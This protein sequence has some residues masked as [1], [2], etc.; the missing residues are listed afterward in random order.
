MTRYTLEQVGLSLSGQRILQPLDLVI[1][2][3]EALALL[4]PSGAGKTTLLRLLSLALSPTKGRLLLDGHN[5]AESTP[6]ALRALRCEMGMVHQDLALVPT[7]RVLD[8]VL[9]GGAGR[10][11]TLGALRRVAFPTQA[12][13]ESV[14]SLLTD[15]GLQDKLYQP[16]RSLSG[17]EAQRVALARA[18]HQQP[19]SLLADEPI[20][21]VDPSQGRALLELMLAQCAQRGITLVLSLHSPALAQAL[22]PRVIG[23]RA[24]RIVSDGTQVDADLY[25]GVGTR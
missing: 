18:L 2:E 14:H 5:V 23:L 20:S 11:S 8:N 4:G 19:R 17:G 25:A 1:Q 13:I 12:E 16:V 3:G 10:L 9:M 7:L 21:S 15:L 24:G 6:K 22:L